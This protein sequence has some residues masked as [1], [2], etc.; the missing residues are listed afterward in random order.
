MYSRCRV[1]VWMIRKGGGADRYLLFFRRKT[2]QVWASEYE[3]GQKRDKRSR[4]FEELALLISINPLIAVA[5]QCP[6]AD[7]RP[8]AHHLTPPS[9]P[10][11]STRHLP[12]ASAALL[13]LAASSQTDAD[14]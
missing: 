12:S 14:V 1:T 10:V 13:S 9:V 8:G 5:P 4:C 6:I 7:S 2:R 11:T 3:R